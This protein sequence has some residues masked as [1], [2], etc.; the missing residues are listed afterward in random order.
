MNN[1]LRCVERRGR[2]LFIDLT[3]LLADK[4]VVRW[5]VDWKHS[6]EPSRPFGRRKKHVIIAS[7]KSRQNNIIFSGCGVESVKILVL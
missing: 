3:E 7:V 2:A 4:S 6:T 1:A 5:S